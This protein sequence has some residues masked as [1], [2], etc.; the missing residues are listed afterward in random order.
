MA[1]KAAAGGSSGTWASVASRLAPIKQGEDMD[2]SHG[3]DVGGSAP[4][5]QGAASSGPAADD[6]F[7]EVVRRRA[8]KVGS[9]ATAEADGRGGAHDGGRAGDTDGDRDGAREAGDDTAGEGDE[10]AEGQPTV[11]D[12]QQCWHQEI[13]LVKRLRGQG[14]SDQHPAMR[15]ACDARDSAERA[16]RGAKEPAPISV[17]LGRAQS[18][19]D[20]AIALQGE[21]RARMLEEERA[22]KERLEA[23]R[24]D[25]DECTSR[26]NLRRQQLQEVQS[27]LGSQ[28]PTRGRMQRAQLEAIRR[29]H[30]TI[31]AEVGPTIAGLVEQL[32]TGAPAWTALNGLLGKLQESRVELENVAAAPADRFDIGDQDQDQDDEHWERWSAWSESH[33]VQGQPWGR[34]AAAGDTTHARG[35]DDDDATMGQSNDDRGQY[36][37]YRGYGYCDSWGCAPRGHGDGDQP[38]G[39]DDWWDTPARRWGGAVRWQAAGH[40]KWARA[41]WADQLEEDGADADDATDPPPPARRRLEAADAQRAEGSDAQQQSPLQQQPQQQQPHQPAPSTTGGSSSEGCPSDDPAVA[42]KKHMERVNK[43]VVMAIEAGVTPLTAA[44]EELCLL[45]AS[46]L[47][48]WVAQCLPSALLC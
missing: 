20:R 21:A 44:G 29:V 8:R 38:M 1:A 25:L 19:L 6:G 13:A 22:Y 11:A 35:D 9:N 31:C 15:A 12:L 18:K 26:V 40:G 36:A 3:G 30:S 7:Q 2:V 16:W 17:R 5:G 14:I 37:G 43:I 4:A 34:G 45:D 23:L 24:A 48:A 28:G 46:Q 39:T 27:E 32:D 10:E 41:S 42:A 47:E 33:D